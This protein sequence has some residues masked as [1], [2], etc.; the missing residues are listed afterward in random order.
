MT[1][2]SPDAVAATTLNLHCAGDTVC[3]FNMSTIAG[4]DSIISRLWNF[5]DSTSV[6]SSN[7]PCHVFSQPGNYIVKLFVTASNGNSDSTTLSISVNPVPTA[8]FS[9]NNVSG[10]VVDFTDL[11]S[12]ASGSIISWVWNFGDSTLSFQH[13]PS[14][15]FPSIG[16]FWVC[17]TASS[18]FGCSN[19]I[20][21]SVGV[22]GAGIEDY[23]ANPFEIFLSPNPAQ[24][25]ITAEIPD[26]DLSPQFEMFDMTGNKF[27]ILAERVK[28]KTFRISLPH[29]ANGVYF[30]K[31]KTLQRFVVLKIAIAN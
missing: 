3:F 7:S 28:E 8:Q 6:D 20:C 11:S 12:V 22:I 23:N 25:E 14:H 18:G 1:D 5:G 2:Y 16:T 9:Y 27:L 15:P 24:N 29:V 26:A 31:V 10:T 19:T 30:L 13:Y 21:D 4:C 17:L